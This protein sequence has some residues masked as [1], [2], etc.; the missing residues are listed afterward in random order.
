[1]TFPLYC[2]VCGGELRVVR[3]NLEDFD[4]FTGAPTFKRYTLSHRGSI[5][6]N[7]RQL[8]AGCF[9]TRFVHL[10]ALGRNKIGYN[11]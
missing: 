3:S 5:W 1:M 11:P 8:L 7:P 2:D 4:V 6:K 9:G 10:E